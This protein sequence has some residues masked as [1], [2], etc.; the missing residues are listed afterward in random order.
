MTIP[1]DDTYESLR[2][3][4]SSEIFIKSKRTRRRF[5][6]IL[7]ANL[8][9]ALATATPDAVVRQ[10]GNQEFDISASDLV[11]AANAASTVI[12]IDRI[13]RVRRLDAFSLDQLTSDVAALAAPMVTGRTFAVRVRRTGNHDWKSH[14]AEVAIGDALYNESAGVDLTSPDV[15]VRVRVEGTKAVVV[16]KSW[17]GPGGLPIGTQSPCLVMLSG[18]IDSP[19]AAWMMMRRGCPIDM[20]H[21]QLECNQ[22]DHALAVGQQLATAWSHGHEV[23]MHVVNFEHVKKELTASAEAKYR[24]VLLKQ[25]MTEAAYRVARG[26]RL[27]LII[28]GDSLGQV[29][30]QTAANLVEIDKYAKAPLLRPL[31][32][33]TKQEIIDRAREIGTF[34]MST[35]AKEVCDLSEGKLVETAAPTGRLRKSMS[36]LR[37]GLIDDALATWES[38]PAS[39]WFPGVPLTRHTGISR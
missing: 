31:L 28:S 26:L 9:A 12:G 10:R 36:Q 4:A 34:E 35:R 24:Q 3:F 14:D 30:S 29:S 27:P 6:P 8:E 15:T 32:A 2:A 38:V 1:M 5:M 17:R 19:V 18:G 11:A 33:F 23:T 22:A 39:E 16:N 7:R 25:L 37:E 21:F 20:L 13:D